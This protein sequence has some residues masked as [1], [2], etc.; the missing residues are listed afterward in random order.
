MTRTA[1]AKANIFANKPEE[2]TYFFT[3]TR[4]GRSPSLSSSNRPRARNGRT[5][6]RHQ[7]P[8]SR[9]FLRAYWPEA[10]I[11]DGNW[12]PP[13]VISG[14]TGHRGVQHGWEAA[15]RIPLDAK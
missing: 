7:T 11:A 12:T 9:V 4:T 15:S 14:A 6:C 10:A 1:A 3:W 13:P 8:S 5:G 2:S